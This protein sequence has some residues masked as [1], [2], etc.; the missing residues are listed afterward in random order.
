MV[1]RTSRRLPGFHFEGQSPQ[2]AEA[3]PRMDVAVFVGF[4][5]SGPLD[6]PVAL[7]DAAQFAA[8]FG[9]DAPL[10]WDQER[11][12][13][14]YAHLAPAVRAFFRNGGSRCWVVRVA[15]TKARSND[16][17]VP[18]PAMATFDSTGHL[19]RIH[20][21]FAQARSEGD[22]SDSV[23]LSTGLLSRPLELIPLSP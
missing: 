6:T 15:G 21:A 10:V 18:A 13:Q 7:E 9:E 17:P 3:L 8:I 1:T 19:E 5:A 11:D 16:F 12:Q 2:L 23:R 20:P 14:I 22:S 4:A